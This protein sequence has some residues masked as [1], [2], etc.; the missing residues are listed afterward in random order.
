MYTGVSIKVKVTST[1]SHQTKC[2][3]RTLS[4]S[5]RS[6]ICFHTLAPREYYNNDVYHVKDTVCVLCLDEGSILI[7]C[8][9][10]INQLVG[11]KFIYIVPI[12]S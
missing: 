12:L 1:H 4:G 2:T 10:G 5:T 3:Q 11:S 8:I 9:H 6:F 7:I